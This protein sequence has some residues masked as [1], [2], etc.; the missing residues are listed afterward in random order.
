[1]GELPSTGGHSSSSV[2]AYT[3]HQLAVKKPRSEDAAGAALSLSAALPPSL[4][5]SLLTV[6]V[7]APGDRAALAVTDCR[8]GQPVDP[9]EGAAPA[10]A[11][12]V[13][14]V[15]IAGLL[16]GVALRLPHLVSPWARDPSTPCLVLRVMPSRGCDLDLRGALG[17]ELSGE[18]AGH[19]HAP[20][21][22]GDVLDLL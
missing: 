20:L 19:A 6:V 3:A 2:T 4:D 15:I 7:P 22:C 10:L 17:R 12:H 14:V 1:M 11:G 5:C 9:L 8:G 16:L 21:L 18:N 13:H